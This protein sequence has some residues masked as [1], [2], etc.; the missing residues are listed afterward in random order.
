M[1]AQPNYPD[2]RGF[3]YSQSGAEI[4]LGRKIFTTFKVTH[5]QA[6]EEGIIG[7]SAAA[8]EVLGRTR[9]K[10]QVGE[11]SLETDDVE[12]AQAFIDHLCEQGGGD[13]FSDVMFI[14]L[15]RYTSPGR[16]AIERELV[17]CRVL[18]VDEDPGDGPEGVQTSFPISFLYRTFNGKKPFRN[19]R[20]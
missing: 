9:G 7:E 12:E 2:T 3:K 5:S 10:M 14:T 8:P 16:A 20:I 6:I 11:G 4:R 15:I 13:G 17:S 19:Q 1:T 18:D